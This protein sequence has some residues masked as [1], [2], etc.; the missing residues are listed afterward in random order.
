[1]DIRQETQASMRNLANQVNQLT[2]RITQLTSQMC[3]K[4]PSQTIIDHEEDESA[5]ILTNDMKL[6]ESQEDRSKDA[7]EKKVK[8]QGMRSQ[9]QI[10]QVNKSSAQSPNTVTSSPFLNQYSLDSYSLIPVSE[11]D[12]ILPENFEFH[13]R[14]KLR[15]MMTKYLELI[16]ALDGGV[17]EDL[18]SLLVCLAPSTN[19]WKTVPRVLKDYSI[20]EG[21]Q[22]YTEDEA[23]KR[24]TRFYPP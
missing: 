17:S 24:A 12:F 20:Y 1:M 15:V 10:T 5:I 7:V 13:D 6:Q 21:Y 3:E 19:T 16:N 8:M 9:H 4:L 14:N 22:D 2:F 23:L 11:I 18:R